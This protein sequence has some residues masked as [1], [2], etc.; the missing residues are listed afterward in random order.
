M[1]RS[2]N[3]PHTP[4]EKHSLRLDDEH[5]DVR[6]L[7]S[8]ASSLFAL[9]ASKESDAPTLA[10][11]PISIIAALALAWAGITSDSPADKELKKILGVSSHEN[12]ASILSTL[13]PIGASFVS[14]GVELKIANS[15]WTRRSIRPS[16]VS[17]IE[18][19]YKAT[20]S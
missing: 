20:A 17:L 3:A 18:D 4:S 16:Y 1:M 9:L 11:S 5:E 14:Q 13:S 7:T 6:H 12:V 19:V 15:V 2:A 8:F 10:V